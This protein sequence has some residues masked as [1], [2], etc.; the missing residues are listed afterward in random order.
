[1]IVSVLLVHVLISVLNVS[2]I[3]W[4]FAG[5]S[6]LAIHWFYKKRKTQKKHGVSNTDW[7]NG[8]ETAAAR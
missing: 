5:F 6:M 8:P 3:H 4:F 2:S 1:M 7:M